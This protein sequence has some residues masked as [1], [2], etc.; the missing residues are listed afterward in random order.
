[1]RPQAPTPEA[2]LRLCVP[3][4]PKLAAL[5]RPELDILQLAINGG[6]VQ[7]IVDRALGTDL[8][9]YTCLVKLTAKGYL[10]A[11]D[12]SVG[13]S[14]GTATDGPTDPAA[15]VTVDFDSQ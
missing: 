7:D 6:A 5:E 3:L 15:Y 1:L 11:A 4:T 14:A 10:T 2:T 8:E 12:A 13:V 9:A